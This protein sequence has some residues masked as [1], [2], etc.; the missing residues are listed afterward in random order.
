MRKSKTSTENVNKDTLK[1]P[2]KKFY[3]RPNLLK[4]QLKFD[5]LAWIPMHHLVFR[6]LRK[7][8]LTEIADKSLMQQTLLT[9]T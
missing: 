3:F 8:G 4:L 2:K 6:Y 5:S 1:N 7:Q 9:G